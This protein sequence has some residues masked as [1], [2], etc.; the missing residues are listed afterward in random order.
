[1]VCN[2]GQGGRSPG[3]MDGSVQQRGDVRESEPLEEGESGA[4]TLGLQEYVVLCWWAPR[5]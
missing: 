5:I 4:G 3:K 1:M 2:R